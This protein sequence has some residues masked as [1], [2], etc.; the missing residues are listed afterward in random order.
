MF[1][2]VLSLAFAVSLLSAATINTTVMCDGVTTV[3]TTLAMCNDP[4]RSGA[5]ASL[6][7]PPFGPGFQV[8]VDAGSAV[9]PNS[10]SASANFMD[11]YVFTMVGGTGNGSYFPCFSGSGYSMA[12]GSFAGIGFEVIDQPQGAFNCFGNQPRGTPKPFTFGVPQIVDVEMNGS[13][14]SGLPGIF[15]E[16]DASASFDGI[17]FFDAS[18]NL[19]QNIHYTLVSVDLPEPSAVSFLAIALV[20]CVAAHFVTRRPQS[21]PTLPGSRP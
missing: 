8:S 15:R 12:G 11:D 14:A 20:F 3:G 16:F 4:F 21:S 7:A 5:Y 18:G 19:L 10:S 6:T 17:L 2:Y 1:R 13:A 9:G